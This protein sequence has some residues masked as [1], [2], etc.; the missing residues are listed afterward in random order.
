MDWMPNLVLAHEVWACGH[1]L[2]EDGVFAPEGLGHHAV[3]SLV[4]HNVSARVREAIAHS[5][6][7]KAGLARGRHVACQH[8]QH[9]PAAASDPLP[10]HGVA[11]STRFAPHLEHVEQGPG[12]SCRRF[13]LGVPRLC[14]RPR[15]RRASAEAILLL[16]VRTESG[17]ALRRGP[18]R[19][20]PRKRG[21]ALKRDA[22][23][24]SRTQRLAHLAAAGQ[25]L[26]PQL[27]LEGVLGA[28]LCLTRG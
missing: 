27:V 4:Q 25:R 5:H 28:R 26:H 9:R 8:R 12:R 20:G 3:T 11:R 10:E 23:G 1:V 21:A 22:R 6:P 19:R 15:R 14:R 17:G 18:R 7:H 24:A 2:D 16:R 13:G